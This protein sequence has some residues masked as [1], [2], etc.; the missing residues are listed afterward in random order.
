[1]A[2]VIRAPAKTKQSIRFHIIIVLQRLFM[3]FSPVE[4]VR[5]P[6]MPCEVPLKPLKA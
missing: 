5:R 4:V 1:M 6:A 3:S 2:T